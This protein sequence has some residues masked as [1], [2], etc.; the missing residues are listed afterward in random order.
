MGILLRVR[1][2]AVTHLKAWAA[3][4]T[5]MSVPSSSFGRRHRAASFF[6]S[7]NTSTKSV[8]LFWSWE[9]VGRAQV[10]WDLEECGDVLLAPGDGE[11]G[12]LL[13]GGLLG[14]QLLGVRGYT[15]VTKVFEF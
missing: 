8:F 6:S 3:A 15:Y 4:A 14:Q 12:R 11:G 5:P 7:S 1:G 2:S 9:G 10:V 13:L